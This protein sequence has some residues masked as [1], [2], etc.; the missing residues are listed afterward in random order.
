M[1]CFERLILGEARNTGDLAIEPKYEVI[2]PSLLL[3]HMGPI[4]EVV[5]RWWHSLGR[6]MMDDTWW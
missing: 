2:R 3:W 5:L 6:L 4:P 1:K